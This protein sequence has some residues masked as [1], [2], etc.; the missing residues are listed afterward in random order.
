MK[1]RKKLVLDEI[2][3]LIIII[4][5]FAIIRVV[6][7]ITLIYLLDIFSLYMSSAIET[8][9]RR[10]TLKVHASVYFNILA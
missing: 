3:S 1:L 6:I 9:V 7:V 4:I 10:M 8:V 2:F 5:A